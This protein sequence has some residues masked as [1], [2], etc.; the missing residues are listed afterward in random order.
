M[1][2]KS[3]NNRVYMEVDALSR[4]EDFDLWYADGELFMQVKADWANE[5]DRVLVF[6]RRGAEMARIKSDN[7]A[8]AYYVGVERYE[9]TLFTHTL[10]KH[11][12]F[13]GMLWDINGSLRDGQLTF[14]SEMADRNEVFVN[15]TRFKGHGECYEIRVSDVSHLRIAAVATVAIAIK[16]EWKGLSE[17]EPQSKDQPWYLKLKDRVVP[18]KGIPYEQLVADGIIEP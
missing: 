10:F 15:K 18:T 9:Y 7:K 11:Y 6:S 8:M 12:F 2:K 13:K 14:F 17:G 3:K 1:A 5:R 16:E 4:H